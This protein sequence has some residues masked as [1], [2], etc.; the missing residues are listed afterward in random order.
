M[1]I[2][3]DIDVEVSLINIKFFKQNAKDVSIRIIITS[4]IVRGLGAHKY[5]TNKYVLVTIY[6]LGKN[7]SGKLV[8]TNFRREVYLIDNFKTN[9]LLKI[10][11]IK[12]EQID[13]LISFIIVYINSCDVTMPICLKI[14]AEALQQNRFI[15]NIKIVIISFRSKIFI[16]VHIIEFLFD[17]NY[18]FEF[19]N[20]AI[21]GIYAHI[22]NTKTKIIQ[23]KNEL[24]NIRISRNY[25]LKK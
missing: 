15:H 21:F 12:F 22:I 13:V 18:L 10:D 19:F 20:F 5:N 8:R 24:N 25:R 9:M 14:K 6:F 4:V 23:I 17:R 1:L 11:I 3:F 7:F 2:C 16:F